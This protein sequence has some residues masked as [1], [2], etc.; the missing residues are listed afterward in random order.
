MISPRYLPALLVLVAAAMVPTLIHSYSDTVATDGRITS[1]IPV[2][3]A[4]YIGAPT[5]RNPNWGK[6]RFESEDWTE[7]TYSR[8]GDEV[9]LTIVR[10]YDPKS[11]YHHPELAVSYG[12]EFDGLETHRFGSHPDIPVHVL[13]PGPGV[14]ARAMYVLLY[15]NRF[16]EAPIAFQIRTAG[17]LLFGRRKPMTL[18]FALDPRVPD[19]A[20]V[21]GLGATRLM[22][23]A[24]ESFLEQKAV[25]VN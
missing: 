17:E 11:L 9:V 2:S 5:D 7:R 23:A 13:V 10:S 8:E 1:E 14:A 22:L 15:D 16:V 18:F 6:R 3:L 24:V 4:D 20:K 12:T 25:G 19:G 21:E